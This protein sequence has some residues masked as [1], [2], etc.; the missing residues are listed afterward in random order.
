[1][2]T[3]LEST[4]ASVSPLAEAGSEEPPTKRIKLENGTHLTPTD[5]TAADSVKVKSE[6]I[7]TA[8]ATATAPTAATTTTLPTTATTTPPI[9]ATT[10]T[11]EEDKTTSS[12][13]STDE[14]SSSA[15]S[16]VGG[17]SGGSSVVTAGSSP[18]INSSNSS[19][20]SN[21]SHDSLTE[22]T[23]T[24]TAATTTTTT[25]T[26][27]A[28]AVA[29]KILT[30]TATTTVAAAAAV[31]VANPKQV[32][33]T[34]LTTPPS[35]TVIASASVAVAAATT[36]KAA[37]VA[38]LPSKPTS[39]TSRVVSSTSSPIPQSQSQSQ[40]Q[41]HYVASSSTSTLTSATSATIATTIAASSADVPLKAL[42][43]G[44][45]QIKYLGELEYMLREFRK[46]ER[47]L[48]GAKGA[49]QLEESAGSRERREKLHS[50]ILHLEDTIR[51]IELGCKLED[52][53]KLSSTCTKDRSS[54]DTQHTDTTTD[55][56]KESA[57]IVG[58]NSSN[59]AIEEAKKQQ[60]AEESALSNLTKE[61][62]EE[63]NVQKL[64]EHI[65]ANLL[66]VKVRLKKQLAAQQG[67][68]QNPAG[69]PS[70]RR[71]SLQ[72]PSTARGR[73][74]FAEAAEKRRKQAEAVRIAAQEQRERA[75]KN[76]SDPSQ[77]GK[78]LSGGGSSLTQ[79]LHGST[80]GSK[81]RRAGSGVG[82][83]SKQ[84]SEV[85]KAKQMD[86]PVVAATGVE[87]KILY[88]GMV[89][90]STQQKSGLS[91]ASGAHE[92]VVT[93]N[94]QGN[95]AIESS[96]NTSG[97]APATTTTPAL[98]STNIIKSAIPV[99]VVSA[100]VQA[101]RV[102]TKATTTI[103]VQPKRIVTT[104]KATN[105]E[106]KTITATIVEAKATTISGLVKQKRPVISSSA[107]MS[108]EEKLKFKKHRRKRKILRLARRRERERL[109]QPHTKSQQITST[110]T[111]SN[112][113]TTVRKKVVLHHSKGP[114]KKGPRVV[115]YI[116]SLCSEAY[117]ST[118]DLNPWWALAQHKCPKCQKTQVSNHYLMMCC[119]SFLLFY[120]RVLK[121]L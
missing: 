44:H 70:L 14:A 43:F 37:P 3:T 79:K 27:P 51:Q 93:S 42:N 96:A 62:E 2:N 74:T 63:E 32:A 110:Q 75:V 31:A 69:M 1:M 6:D 112:N 28:V 102:I 107:P 87:R 7:A 101:S 76:V 89:P 80:L 40:L 35:T 59:D 11:K 106:A 57:D 78:P 81:Q 109:K 88:A 68:T 48:L 103:A 49:A 98:Q 56:A 22:T 46:L 58:A 30:A 39:T 66:P 4:S 8:T 90:G 86:A 60:M 108:E 9:T 77:F 104:P 73:G 61:K 26:A 99:P 38:V 67:A 53:G 13:T 33:V 36:T 21:S 105:A 24:A 10:Q 119:F 16:Q 114:K 47:Q 12:T 71:G 116:C 20:N 91:A 92:M 113:P 19:H 97:S 118:C 50:F 120:F 115:E 45:L 111:P 17:G 29:A 25:N 94:N 15:A 72:P 64:E 54:N 83:P 121:S 5:G 117:S 82:T 55:S 95:N 18:H 52:E 34:P 23:A 84:T 65:L 100:A 85:V 41:P